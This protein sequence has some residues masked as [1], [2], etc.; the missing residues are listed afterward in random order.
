[1]FNSL[2]LLFYLIID[3]WLSNVIKMNVTFCHGEPFN[4]IVP[5]VLKLNVKYLKN[6]IKRNKKVENDY[7]VGSFKT[8][9]STDNKIANVQWENRK[10]FILFE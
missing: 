5:E 2:L 3:S 1:M 9:L 8:F 7:L 10:V 4:R 6:K